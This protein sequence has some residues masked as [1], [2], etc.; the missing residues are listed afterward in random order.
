MKI[1]TFKTIKINKKIYF[2][3]EPVASRTLNLE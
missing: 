2:Y 3:I 1:K